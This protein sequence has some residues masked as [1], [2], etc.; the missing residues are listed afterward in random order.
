MGRLKYKEPGTGAIEYAKQFTEGLTLEQSAPII[1]QLLRGEL[2]DATDR[3][4]KRCDYC[5]YYWRD[6]SL[7]NT[8][9]TCCEDCKRSLKTM[10]RRQQR[11]DKELL[12]PKPR[13]RTLM[14]DY[15]WWLEYPF[16]INEYSMIKIGWKYEVP[17]APNKL[18][19]IEGAKERS[20]K[21]G[22][23]VKPKIQIPY[24]GEN[25]EGVIK[26]HVINVKLPITDTKPGKVS[27]FVMSDPRKYLL[28]KYGEEKL[29]LEAKRAKYLSG[30]K[31]V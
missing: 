31:K 8:K 11:A 27:H 28:E 25:E 13:K 16:W 26:S 24:S 5:G 20:Y 3:R 15:I 21:M 14:D 1:A 9:R 4:I 17:C 10:Q 23:R 6:D 7:R 19:R 12:N 22:G 30:D 29:A 18:S 2:H